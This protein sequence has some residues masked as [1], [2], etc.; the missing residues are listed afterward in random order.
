V[1]GTT[2]ILEVKRVRGS[3]ITV[4]IVKHGRHD[5]QPEGEYE[6]E[7]GQIIVMTVKRARTYALQVGRHQ[8]MVVTVKRAGTTYLLEVKREISSWLRL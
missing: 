8:I 5:I 2:Y 4:E 7:T 6:G 3:Q 1:E